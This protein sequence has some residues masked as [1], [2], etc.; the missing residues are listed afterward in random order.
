MQPTLAG[1][2]TFIRNVMGITTAQL[3]DNSPTI[4]FAFSVALAIVNPALQAISIPSTDSTGAQLNT[5]NF[6]IYALAVYNLAG[7]NVIVFA[8]DPAGAPVYKN[9]QTYFE[10]TRTAFNINGF[11]SGVVQATSD[12]GTSTNLVVMEVAK[13]FTLGDLENLKD[14]YGR[15]YLALAQDYGPSTWGMT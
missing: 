8:Q 7:H 14:P 5:G 6:S 15:R 1:F 10:Y 3:P 4:G 2:L 13:Q 11:V 9:N 12:E